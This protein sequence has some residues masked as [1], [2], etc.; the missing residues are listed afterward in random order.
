MVVFLVDAQVL[1]QLLDGVQFRVHLDLEPVLSFLHA[2]IQRGGSRGQIAGIRNE[3]APQSTTH[4]FRTN[5]I[6]HLVGIEADAALFV[7]LAE[8][9]AL[10]DPLFP[11]MVHL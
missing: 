10:V 5:R 1:G 4:A 2:G 3:S 9:L 7:K 6:W 11:I 8:F